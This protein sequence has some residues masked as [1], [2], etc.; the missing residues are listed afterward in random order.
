MG[1]DAQL[2]TSDGWHPAAPNR[3]CAGIPVVAQRALTGAE[4]DAL[5][6]RLGA[7]RGYAILGALP[8]LAL[9]AFLQA[10]AHRSSVQPV[11]GVERF[12]LLTCLLLGPA[13]ALA[14]AALTAFAI[15]RLLFLHADLKGGL[16][17][18]FKGPIPDGALDVG[19]RTLVRARL[20]R[21][22]ATHVLE[23]IAGS[24]RLASVDHEP[25]KS[26]FVVDITEVAGAALTGTTAE[27]AP[28]ANRTRR[29]DD[30]EAREL[31][32]HAR[33]FALTTLLDLVLLVLLIGV[34]AGVVS[35]HAPT[36]IRAPIALAVFA[37][38]AFVFRRLLVAARLTRA[39]RADAIARTVIAFRPPSEPDGEPEP[40]VELLGNSKL[41]WTHDGRPTRWRTATR[42]APESY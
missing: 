35:L 33:R 3:F 22:G 25:P 17:L 29:L 9:A 39:V 24:G 10:L 11:M 8:T 30:D 23:V 2:P 15:Q 1:D 42:R 14:G 40:V 41:P 31:N 7:L 28:G 36:R 21:S 6:A 37:G 5:R 18:R 19:A 13:L 4:R 27:L 34:F 12:L 26:H 38:A 32:A 16:V 20:V